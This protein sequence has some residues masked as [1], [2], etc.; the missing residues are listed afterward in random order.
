TNICAARKRKARR[1]KRDL[2][3]TSTCSV[4]SRASGNPAALSS[5]DSGSPLARGRTRTETVTRV[6]PTRGASPDTSQQSAFDAQC[7]ACRCRRLFRARIAHHVGDLVDCG[8]PPD[9]RGRTMLRDE[10]LL[11]LLLRNA[12][13]LRQLGEEFDHTLRPCRA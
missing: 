11:H 3:G 12:L 5:L 6:A 2:I 7:C 4:R 1:C 13:L 10:V 9:D 8:E